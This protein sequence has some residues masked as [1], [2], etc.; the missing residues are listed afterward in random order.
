MHKQQTAAVTSTAGTRW[1]S[2]AASSTVV[3]SFDESSRAA[4][5][6]IVRYVG[7]RSTGEGREYTM[8]VADGLSSREFVLLITHRAFAAREA[9]FQ[10]A[11]DVCSVKLRRALADEPDLLPGDCIAVTAEDLLE[12]RGDH[13]SPLEKRARAKP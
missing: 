2:D 7:F 5:Q 6:P 9:R 4:R 3:T 1:G 13:L 8:R 12:Y 10:D 11:P